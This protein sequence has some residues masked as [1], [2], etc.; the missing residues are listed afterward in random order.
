MMRPTLKE[1]L[2]L[3]EQLLEACALLDGQHA[4]YR[5]ACDCFSSSA[6]L[7]K[8]CFQNSHLDKPSP[9]SE[10]Q[11]QHLASGVQSSDLEFFSVMFYPPTPPHPNLNNISP[12]PLHIPAATFLTSP[13]RTSLPAGPDK[14]GQQGVPGRAVLLQAG[15]RHSGD[16]R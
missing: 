12:G 15:G 8:F 14:K 2:P 5:G 1:V 11:S 7:H 6:A 13:K 4:P 3:V 9:E 10:A 16:I